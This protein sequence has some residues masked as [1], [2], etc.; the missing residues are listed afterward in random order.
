MASA[1]SNRAHGIRKTT[2]SD[3][4]FKYYLQLIVDEGADRTVMPNESHL[5]VVRR[6]VCSNQSVEKKGN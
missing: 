1:V 5:V 2:V 4:D 6:D 3:S